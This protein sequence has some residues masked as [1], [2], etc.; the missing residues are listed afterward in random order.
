MRKVIGFLSVGLTV[1]FLSVSYAPEVSAADFNSMYA[2][3]KGCGEGCNI[4]N[5]QCV[6]KQNSNSSTSENVSNS[7]SGVGSGSGADGD[8]FTILQKKLYNTLRDLRQIV[9]VIAGFGLVVFAVAAI[10]NK[11]SYKHLGYIMIGLSLLALMFPFLEYF[12]GYSLESEAQ[13]QLTFKNYLG[14]YNRVRGTTDSDVLD[15][16]GV[17]QDAMTEEEFARKKEEMN[18]LFADINSTDEMNNMNNL[19]AENGGVQNMGEA[20]GLAGKNP[21]EERAKQIEEIKNAGCSLATMKSEWNDT[22]GTRKVCSLDSGGRLQVTLE[23]CQG[24]LKDGVCSKTFGQI[25]GDV[26]GTA[27]D[28]IQTFANAGGIVSNGMTAVLG[29]GMTWNSIEDIFN[30]D[31]SLAEKFYAAGNTLANGF[32]QSGGVVGN[33]HSMIGNMQAITQNAGNTASRWSSNY[34]N[35]VTGDNPF[36]SAMD[37][38]SGYGSDISGLIDTGGG[39]VNSVTNVGAGVHTQISNIDDALKMFTGGTTS[40]GDQFD[41][42]YNDG[43]RQSAAQAQAEALQAQANALS[44]LTSDQINDAL[45]SGAIT[46]EQA[47]ALRAYQQEVAEQAAAQAAAEAQAY[48]QAQAQAA[49]AAAD[50]VSAA[51][52]ALASAQTPGEIAAAMEM[53]KKAQQQAEEAQK[54]ADEAQKAAKGTQT[55][56]QGN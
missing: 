21:V 7:G 51:E 14:D 13:K 36:T 2:E 44:Q 1:L 33:L 46:Q 43:Q 8:I 28:A 41:N 52:A 17:T 23:T 5:G 29:A 27:R 15:G 40:W 47:Q 30:S 31:L 53:L 37:M 54:A 10:F 20:E 9:Y 49:Q 24:K 22:D 34:E 45:S 11:I 50:N 48:A 32:G 16:N 4:I 55:N 3:A 42:V 35:N 56:G 39:Y 19:F 18:N 26:T 12:S 38:L 6:C 25:I